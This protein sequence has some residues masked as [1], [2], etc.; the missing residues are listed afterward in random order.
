MATTLTAKAA[1]AQQPSVTPDAAGEVYAVRGSIDLAAA[2]GLGDVIEMVKLPAGCVPVDFIIDTDDLDSG[3]APAL[4]MSVGLTAGTVAELRAAGA[5]GQAA[6][7]VRMDSVLAP[8]VAAT[9]ADRT[10]GLKVTTAPATGATS[11]TIG[12]TLLYR[13]AHY[14]A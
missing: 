8:R 6:G 7:L 2:L 4:A 13:A 11:G 12:L 9:N 5:V 3:G 14:G 10:V 1:T